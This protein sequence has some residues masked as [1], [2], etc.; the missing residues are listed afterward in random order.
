VEEAVEILSRAFPYENR[1]QLKKSAAGY[2]VFAEMLH[3]AGLID[4]P[5][6]ATYTLENV[7]G[8]RFEISCPAVPFSSGARPRPNPRPM[9]EPLYRRLAGRAYAFE[10]LEAEKTLYLAYNSCRD[11]E[12]TPFSE[13][14]G[15][16]FATADRFPVDRFVIDLRANGGGDS[17]VFEPLIAGLE[18]RGDLNRRGRLFVVIGR[19]TFSSAVLNAIQLK[20]R[21][22]AVFVGEPSGG[23][24]NH[25]GEVKMF[26][27]ANSGL[28]VTYSTKYF[29]MW[30]AGGDAL[31][32]DIPVAVYFK[33]YLNNRDPVLERITAGDGGRR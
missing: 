32:P 24:P 5:G 12:E 7:T 11:V 17:S 2:L 26:R 1:S 6:R 22:R 15:Q 14:S 27:L 4:D 18:K 9:P 31:E 30:E 3:G 25:F 29:T 19:G 28:P 13:F 16:V 10:Y 20:N 33:D 23:K 8:D 21:T